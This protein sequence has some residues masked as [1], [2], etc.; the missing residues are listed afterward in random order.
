M[1]S[2]CDNV[3][4]I[5]RQPLNKIFNIRL[6]KLLK[7]NKNFYKLIVKNMNRFMSTNLAKSFIIV[8]LFKLT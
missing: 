5:T 7:D 2:Y 8:T 4:N 6:Q 1:S 3:E